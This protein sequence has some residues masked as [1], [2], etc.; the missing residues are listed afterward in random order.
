MRTCNM[1]EHGDW[2][3]S[4]RAEPAMQPHPVPVC[5]RLNRLAEGNVAAQP[6]SDHKS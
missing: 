4:L 2:L 6:R 5:L 1:A 3:A